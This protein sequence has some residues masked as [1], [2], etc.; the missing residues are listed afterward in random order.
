[1]YTGFWWANLR[2]RQKAGR[3]RRRLED[4]RKM[5]IQEVGWDIS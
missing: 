3:L 5:S 1:M 4:N 2:K